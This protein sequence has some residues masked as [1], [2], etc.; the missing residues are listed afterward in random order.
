MLAEPHGA[1][2]AFGARRSQLAAVPRK[3]KGSGSG[4]RCGLQ[5]S[6]LK[7]GMR[8]MREWSDEEDEFRPP[9]VAALLGGIKRGKKK[10]HPLGAGEAGSEARAQRPIGASAETLEQGTGR[11]SGDSGGDGAD[12]PEERKGHRGVQLST[13]EKIAFGL[14]NLATAAMFLPTSIHINKF[15][16]DTLLVKPGTLALATAVARAFDTLMDPFFGW[17]SDNTTTRWGRRKP[18]LA[19]CA[20]LSA[21]FYFL[22]FT[23]PAS[24]SSDG[25][26]IWFGIFFSLFLLL[27]VTLPHHALG[28]ELTLDYEERSSLYAWSESFTLIGVIA[29]AAA[30]GV[31]GQYIADTR[32]IFMI[33]AATVAVLLVATFALLLYVLKEP[34]QAVHQGNPLVPGL[35]RAWRN[36][37]FRVLVV[38]AIVGSIAHHCSALMF[39]FYISYVL[40]P[41][42][43]TLWLSTCL[44]TYFGCSALSIPLWC[45]LAQHYDK[46]RIWLLGWAIM[47]PATLCMFF[48]PEDG[49]YWLLALT[50]LTGL[51]FGGSSYLY[52]AIQADTID[53]D[54][55]RTTRRREGQYIT[56]WALV[57]KLVAIPA[58]SIPLV[59]LESSGYVANLHPQPPSVVMTIRIMTTLLPCVLAAIALLIASTYPISREKNAQISDMIER[60]R[61]AIR[62]QTPLPPEKDPLTG[63][64][65]PQITGG[66]TVLSAEFCWYLD[67]FSEDE[68]RL[69]LDRGQRALIWSVAISI[70]I[71]IGVAVFA[72]ALIWFGSTAV[73]VV[74]VMG[75]SFCMAIIIFHA[76]RL[77]AA[78]QFD[79]EKIHTFRKGKDEYFHVMTDSDS[80]PAVAGAGGSGLGS[81]ARF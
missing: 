7:E 74:G 60:R 13:W 54:E 67:Y 75:V 52:K 18:Y 48:V 8:S 42:N 25:A 43:D 33:M 81:G 24:L 39:P 71:M 44:L 6:A 11:D 29:A 73:K 59:I 47:L 69:V 22:L 77:Q 28:P 34:A 41:A 21:L 19:I 3:E 14:P 56:F 23:P 78:R 68:L 16:A 10:V 53:Y 35:R 79:Q 76:L 9:E 30:P 61:T 26:A 64:D 58:A 2:R 62:N 63:K 51:S 5:A 38:T 20:P 1:V 27:P 66:L 55:L 4:E 12:E 31:L 57:P 80:A 32:L 40:H 70:Y 46:K 15:F 37:P 72:A 49:V 17:L 65:L 36:G 45:Y 50:I